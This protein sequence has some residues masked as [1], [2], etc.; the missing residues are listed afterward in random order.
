MFLQDIGL[1]MGV[2]LPGVIPRVVYDVLTGHGIAYGGV[3][4]RGDTPG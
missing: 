2:W 1:D 4:A 3:A